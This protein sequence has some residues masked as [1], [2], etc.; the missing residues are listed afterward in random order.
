MTFSAYDRR[1]PRNSPATPTAISRPLDLSPTAVDRFLADT[2]EAPEFPGDPLVV[3]DVA[4]ELRLAIDML[5]P[6]LLTKSNRI[7]EVGAGSGAVTA[8]L[9][10]QGADIVGVEP[11][12]NSFEGFDPIRAALEAAGRN[13]GLLA[14]RADQLDPLVFG[15][16]DVIF[17]VNVI[18][19]F[20]PLHPCLDGMARVLS[21]NG[22]MVHTCPN[23]RLPY[24]PHLRAPL[25][26]GAPAWTGRLWPPMRGH[27]VWPTLNW[28]TAHDIRAFA[29]RH[30]LDLRFRPGQLAATLDRLKFDPAFAR[31]QRSVARI[32]T[33]PVVKN[34]LRRIPTTWSTPM[35]FEL[36]RRY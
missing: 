13:P 30:H 9:A 12:R 22:T 10:Q 20:Q 34:A 31:R 11:N 16:F 32:V 15:Y 35:T 6:V 27:P 21:A 28:V 25:V 26:P 19:H 36:E 33:L 8:F 1:P 2:L 17:S 23:Y 14:L 5:R 7:L 18:E 24:E 3:A 4:F 29:D